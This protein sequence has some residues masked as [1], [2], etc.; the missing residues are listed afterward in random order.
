MHVMLIGAGGREHALAWKLA[1][2]KGV[3]KITVAPGNPG[4]RA[5]G[6]KIETLEVP[7]EDVANLV[8]WASVQYPDLVVVGPEA[9]ICEG[10]AD[11]LEEIDIACFAPSEEAAKIE[12]SKRFMKEIA[13]EAGVPTAAYG[14]FD[15][16]AAALEWLEARG[17]AMVVKADGLAA[18]KGVVV[19]ETLEETRGAVE[20]M[21]AG[22]F[23]HAGERVVLEERLEGE[24][25]SFFAISDGERVLPMI[26]SQDH[27]RAFDGDEG[28]NTGGMGAY[29]PAP[30][31]TDDVRRQ[32]IERIIQPTAD[33]LA[34]RGTP[35]R[36]VFYAGLMVGPDGPKLIEFNAR[37][38]DPECQ[39]MMRL[40]KSDL[41]PVLMAA[42]EGD[43]SG[44]AFEW[45]EEACALVV[46]ATKGYPEGYEKGSV[47]GGL[48][49]AGALPGVEVFHAGTAERDGAI[50]ASGGRVLNVTATAPSLK[51]ALASAYA[52]VD[53]IDWPEG[54]HRRDI[55]WRAL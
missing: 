41:A 26:G 1:G 55:G 4:M 14:A 47:I 27:K 36:G 49:A 13:A 40:L 43:L 8:A 3:D 18:G 48:D 51:E 21:F 42:A 38:G 35:Y 30:V 7:A 16:K 32:T 25:A 39:V 46:M 54:F 24:E 5:L 53:A 11:R 31:F 6:P 34:A 20:E 45:S 9:P 52:G 17:E 50:L 33:A 28:P 44:R 19:C 15:D 2:E 22:R 23:G 12:A 37:F 29:S 10:I